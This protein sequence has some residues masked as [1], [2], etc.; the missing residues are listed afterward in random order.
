MLALNSPTNRYGVIAAEIYD[1]DKPPGK[2]PDTAFHLSRLADVRGEIL[3]PA[4]GSG[5]TLLPLL[6]AGHRV[7]G[8][9]PSPEMLARARDLCA[10]FATDL[11][12]QRMESFAYERRFAAIVVPVGT[13][14]LLDD[15]ADATR[16]LDLF[17]AHLEPGGK[18]IVD[19]QP[20]AMLAREG[21]DRR[22][23][24]ASN[25]DLLTIEG[26]RVAT[27]WL[28]Q[29]ADY[30]LRYER[31][32]ENRLVAAEFEPMAQRYWGVEEF[33][34]ALAR[35]GFAEIVVS[36]DYAW[37]RAPTPGSRVLTYEATAA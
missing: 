36:A 14:T 10:A 27:D 1:L 7:A 8:F 26:V 9:E 24:T 33:R 35:A 13:F 34:M 25:G 2:L 22:R 17:H 30:T 15:F 6:E 12:S 20:L 11:T 3:E 16:A 28:R 23:W 18:L 32:R 19:I 4:C 37:Q 5:R 29:R 21:D 31:W